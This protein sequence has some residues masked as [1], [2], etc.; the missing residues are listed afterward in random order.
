[1]L[2]EAVKNNNIE[3]VKKAL[4]NGEDIN[5]KNNDGNTALIL[6]SYEGYIE[7]VKLLL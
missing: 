7:I 4:L 6:A 3:D 5:I 2:L 1:M